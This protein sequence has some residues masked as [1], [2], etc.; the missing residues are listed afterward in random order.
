[1]FCGKVKEFL[2]Q[3]EIKYTERDVTKDPK[4]IDELREM[5]IMTT[6]VVIIDSAVIVGFDENKL[7]ELIT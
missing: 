1:M 2:S 6:P 3:K 5:G 7:N 4:A